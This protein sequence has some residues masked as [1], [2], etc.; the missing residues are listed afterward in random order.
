MADR[1]EQDGNDNERRV[2]RRKQSKKEKSDDEIDARPDQVHPFTT[3]PIRKMSRQR[4]GEELD[5]GERDDRV[6]QQVTTQLQVPNSVGEDKGRKNIEW[7]LLGE[8]GEC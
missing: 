6:E 5:H 4:D 1:P 8:P 7:C 2:F 3:D